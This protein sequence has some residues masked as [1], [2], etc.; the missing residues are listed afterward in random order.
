MSRGGCR[1]LNHAGA[2]ATTLGA[3]PA[4][5]ASCKAG[6]GQDQTHH[7][8]TTLEGD[9]GIWQAQASWTG[10]SEQLRH[11]A[12][13]QNMQWA[14]Y[15]AP[16]CYS[17][18]V[19][20]HL[21]VLCRFLLIIL[22]VRMRQRWLVSDSLQAHGVVQSGQWCSGS[23]VRARAIMLACYS[24]YVMQPR[25]EAKCEISFPDLAPS[26]SHRQPPWQLALAVLGT[27]AH[28]L[29]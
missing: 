15:P 21:G 10:A 22:N 29:D 1:P 6:P 5:H 4:A 16:Q 12:G 23:T 8:Y 13:L 19:A 18:S 20:E 7:L 27:D 2:E 11:G 3:S 17:L 9:S 26:L 25:Q 14:A 24:R 28:H